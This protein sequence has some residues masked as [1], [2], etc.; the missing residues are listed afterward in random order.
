MILV[1]TSVWID[2]WRGRGYTDSLAGLIEDQ[3]VLTHDLVI[4][5]LA[6][7]NLG[8]AR[9]RDEI[10]AGLDVLPRTP[11]ADLREVLTLVRTERLDGQGLGGMDVHLLASARLAAASLWTADK[12]LAAAAE[13]LGMRYR[14]KSWF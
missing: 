8:P 12:K 13:V 9:V 1:D 10:L 3:L 4:A 2:F 5:E 11:V 7:G 14:W 6:V